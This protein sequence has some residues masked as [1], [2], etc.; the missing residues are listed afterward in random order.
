MK[1]L[2]LLGSPHKKGG[3]AQLLFSALRAA[4]K[5]KANTEWY[6]LYDGEIKPCAGCIQNEGP[7]CKFPCI[8]E[9]YGKFLL[10]KIYEAEG[11]IFATPIYWFAPSGVMKNLLDRMTSLENMV[12]YGEPSYMEG[13]VVG[14]VVVGADTG[15]IMTG[16]YLITTL[17]SMGAV[18]P[19]WAI[20]YSYKSKTSLWDDKD[21][22]NAINVGLLVAKTV[23][24]LKGEKVKLAYE[25]DKGLLEEIRK[26]VLRILEIAGE[27]RR[28]VR[29]TG[30]L[31]Y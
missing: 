24:L 22:L 14:A 10:Q 29:Q 9:D 18:I 13:K 4:E 19:P 8:Y 27:P 3:T 12:A 11:I 15:A 31:R 7:E 21:L 1:I 20:A 30:Y 17:N 2:G 16:G 23:A 6:S 28:Y 26:E 25:E 5:L